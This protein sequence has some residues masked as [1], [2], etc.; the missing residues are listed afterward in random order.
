MFCESN[1]LFSLAVVIVSMININNWPYLGINNFQLMN[2]ICRCFHGNLC[3]VTWTEEIAQG[4]HC[5]TGNCTESSEIK[6]LFFGR[7]DSS[8]TTFGDRLLIMTRS[9]GKLTAEMRYKSDPRQE[10]QKKKKM[11]APSN[12]PTVP[13]H[14]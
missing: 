10:Y 2:Q 8:T 14:N 9:D 6:V 13:G 4:L 1:N 11:I 7:A 3:G 12:F 5:V